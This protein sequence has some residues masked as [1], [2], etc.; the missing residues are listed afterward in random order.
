MAGV[1]LL[2]ETLMPCGRIGRITMSVNNRNDAAADKNNAFV[3]QGDTPISPDNDELSQDELNNVAGGLMS[4][5]QDRA[6]ARNAD[7]SGAFVD[8]NDAVAARNADTNDA[9]SV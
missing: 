1:R 9:A 3:D 7:T 8:K 6:A 2:T 5:G 4:F